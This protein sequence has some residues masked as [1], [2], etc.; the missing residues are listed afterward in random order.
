MEK[1]SIIRFLLLA[2]LISTTTFILGRV[3]DISLL[4]IKS[5]INSFGIYAP[6]AYAFV[7]LLG[8][9]VPFNPVSDFLV[10]NVAALA[11]L[12][13]VSI[14]ATFIVHTTA[15]TLNYYVG[16]MYGAALIKRFTTEKNNE[17]IR[18]LTNKLTLKRLFLLRFVLP[19]SNFIGVEIISYAAGI[20]KLPFWKF[21]I[22]SIVPWTILSVIY[23]TTTTYLLSQATVFAIL[24][25]IVLVAIPTIIFAVKTNKKKRSK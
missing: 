2:L 10:V 13:V 24:P 5:F 9:C 12:P 22:A 21:Y 17:Y 16:R 3:F 6:M 7:L 14:T 18:T 20:E 1:K 25:I 23:F 8:L 4:D 11:F 15:L 19:T